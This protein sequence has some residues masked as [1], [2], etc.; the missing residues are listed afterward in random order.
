MSI[1]MREELVDLLA[2]GNHVGKEN[3]EI[4]D[5]ISPASEM[6]ICTQFQKS[7]N[8]HRYLSE[9]AGEDIWGFS[10]FL[11]ICLSIFHWPQTILAAKP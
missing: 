7:L 11:H 8:K 6:T 1:Q 10:S 9:A 5:G 4:Q 2:T 3:N